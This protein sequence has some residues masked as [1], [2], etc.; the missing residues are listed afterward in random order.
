MQGPIEDITPT[1]LTTSVL[2]TL[3]QA[4]DL[5]NKVLARHGACGSI[6]YIYLHVRR[7]G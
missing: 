7:D 6:Y 3:R 1:H 2:A 5:A 4:D